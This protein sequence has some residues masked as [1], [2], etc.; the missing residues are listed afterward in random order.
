LYGVVLCTIQLDAQMQLGT[1]EVEDV[2]TNTELSTPTHTLYLSS[3]ETNPEGGF[4]S[5]AAIAE[6]LAS[7]SEL[8]EVI[9]VSLVVLLHMGKGRGFV[10]DMEILIGFLVTP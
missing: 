9:G 3:L 2:G 1:I 4:C 7:G 6:F 8:F 5:G 10:W